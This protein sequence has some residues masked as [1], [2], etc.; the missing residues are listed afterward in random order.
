LKL[1]ETKNDGSRHIQNLSVVKLWFCVETSQ[2]NTNKQQVWR[3]TKINNSVQWVDK[4]RQQN[5]CILV[6]KSLPV[7]VLS[8]C[9]LQPGLAR[10]LYRNRK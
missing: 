1:T 8:L 6:Y 9:I 2:R 4:L 10:L 3:F 7:A 5:I